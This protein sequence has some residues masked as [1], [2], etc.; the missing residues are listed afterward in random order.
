MDLTKQS[1]TTQLLKNYSNPIVLD[2][3]TSI[4][5]K[6][7][8]FSTK[9]RLEMVVIGFDGWTKTYLP[10]QFTQLIRELE[11]SDFWITFN[12][13]FDIHWIRRELGIVPKSVWDC[14]I[15]EFLFSDQLWKY[16]SLD[17]SCEK[18]GLPR[19]LDVVKEEYWN[20]GIDTSEIPYDI[21]RDYA[22]QDK[23]STLALFHEQ[24]KLFDGEH[25]DK[26]K[27]FRAQCND[28]L[29]LQEIE[30]N[31]IL[32]D[33]DNSLKAA[34]DLEEQIKKI[35]NTITQICQISF[36]FNH[37]S[38]Q[39][40]SKLLYGG[41]I[42]EEFTAPIG[43]YKTGLRKGEVKMKKF[44]REHL[45]ER[46]VEP[47]QGSEMK[48]EGIYATDEETLSALKAVGLAKKVIK[49]LLE[50]AKLAKMNSTYLQGWPNRIAEQD[51]Q[52]NI[53][54]SNLNQC[55]VV[56]GRLSSTKPNIQNPTKE[57]KQFCISRF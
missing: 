57:A 7:H 44:Q 28:L 24:V 49:L 33:V 55:V 52:D 4:Y 30:Y 19:K 11:K 34:H 10:Q 47:L 37:D 35:D 48:A 25:A 8:P 9:N 32:Y 15:A 41:V 50:R 36:P 39:Q 5:L 1:L 20:K 51:W 53:I 14:Q 21:L 26:Y 54:H 18:R 3:E 29:V 43:V 31:G 38:R 12:G 45:L 23:E 40:I 16:P 17:E 56:S 27:L 46:I 2:V 22:I 13:K 42:E 6:G